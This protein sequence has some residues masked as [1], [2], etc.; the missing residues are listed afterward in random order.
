MNKPRILLVGGSKRIE[1]FTFALMTA[2]DQCLVRRGAYT[3]L[4]DLRT[5]TLPE[6]DPAY[7]HAP[8]NHPNY[9]LKNLVKLVNQANAIVL[10]SPIYHNSYSGI[11][12]NALD[13]LSI[14]E[15]QYKVVGLAS[16]GGNRTTQA[17][18][19]LRIVVRSLSA[20]TIPT[21]VC[22]AASDFS[23]ND[24]GLP[25]L[26]SMPLKERVERFTLEILAICT[27]LNLRKL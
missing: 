12:K 3:E 17:V 4:I 5:Y 7:H 15:F 26:T 13:C 25:T 19:Q 14:S 11:L 22:T 20:I 21:Q 6:A 23:I 1:S 10:A 24:Q 27:S 2:I 16:H 18:D 8:A 9:Q